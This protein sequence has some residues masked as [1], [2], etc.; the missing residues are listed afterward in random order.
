MHEQA[1]RQPYLQRRRSEWSRKI[2]ELLAL[3]AENDAG[4]GNAEA[5]GRQMSNHADVGC[6]DLRA[7]EFIERFSARES[8][9]V[10]AQKENFIL[11]SKNALSERI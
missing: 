4:N 2:Q 9:I 5:I 3:D 6:R 7:R 10:S 1:P 8:K 11:E